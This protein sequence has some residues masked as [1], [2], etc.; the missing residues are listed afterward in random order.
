MNTADES[1][2]STAR[3]GWSEIA[4]AVIIYV[5]GVAI[6]GFWMIRTPD[7]QAIFRINV[8][9][10]ANGAIGLTALLAAYLMRVRAWHAFGFRPTRPKWLLIAAGLGIFAFGL[11]FVVEAIYFHFVTEVNTQADFE[12]AA[13][14]GF[15]SLLV[16]L[17]TGAVLGPIGEEL[18]FRGV[19][20]SALQKYGRWISIIG[21]AAIFAVVH[22]P[23]V[24]MIDA[25]VVGLLL[26]FLFL[27]SA[28]IWPAI[29]LHIVYNGLN[30]IYYSTN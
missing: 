5:V 6:L 28:S 15:L 2:K 9:G 11:I 10:V 4:I 22:G 14:G 13:Q 3:P 27:R 23:S 17:F 21:S 1:G 7:D 26:G 20:A 29:V 18:V 24:I 12:A 25:F 16:L 30:L 19:V 8:G